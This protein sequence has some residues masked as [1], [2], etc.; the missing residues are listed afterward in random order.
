MWITLQ[1]RTC[2]VLL[3]TCILPTCIQNIYILKKILVISLKPAGYLPFLLY[4]ILFST[5]CIIGII[6]KSK[7]KGAR[8]LPNFLSLFLFLQ[9]I[10]EIRCWKGGFTFRIATSITS[11]PNLDTRAIFSLVTGVRRRIKKAILGIIFI[12]FTKYFFHHLVRLILYHS[13]ILFKVCYEGGFLRPRF[14]DYPEYGN[15]S[16]VVQYP[17]FWVYLVSS[18]V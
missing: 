9:I 11:H 7:K 8:R 12:I 10:E 2:I 14:I 15:F 16:Q 4:I 13:F 5:L 17:E 1:L 18:G 6:K 3:L